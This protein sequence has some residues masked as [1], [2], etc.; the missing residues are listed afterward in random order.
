MDATN[1]VNEYIG[2]LRVQHPD[3]TADEEAMVR[4]RYPNVIFRRS[5]EKAVRLDLR[6]AL[7]LVDG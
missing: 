4:E 3:L 2:K 5:P 7:Y 6:L 1:E